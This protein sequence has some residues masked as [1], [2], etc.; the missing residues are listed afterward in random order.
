MAK[1]YMTSW[2]IALGVL[3][4]SAGAAAQDAEAG[5]GLSSE[6][7]E[8]SASGPDAD[9]DESEGVWTPQH[10]F[11]IGIFAGVMFPPEDP[12]LRDSNW[13]KPPA[14]FD[15][16]AFDFGARAGLFPIDYLGLEGELA[17]IPTKTDL[18]NNANVY[19]VRGHLVG[20]IPFRSIT[21][22]LVIGGTTLLQDS[23]E[24]G[25]DDDRAFH[26]GIGA[27]MPISDSMKIRL[28]LRDTISDKQV[29][30]DPPHWP[31]ILLGLSLGLGGE[32]EPPPPPEP[33]DSDGDGL[34]DDVDKCP[35]EPANTPDGCPIPDS[36]GDGVLDPDDECPQEPGTLPNGCPDLDPDKDGILLPADQCPDVAGIAPDGCPDPDPDKDGFLGD[37]DKCPEQP[38]TKNGFEDTDGCPDDVPDKVKKFSGVI[39]GINFAT[40]K[41][42]IKPESFPILDEAVEVLKEY[43]SLNLLISGHTDSVGRPDKNQKL[44][45]DRAASVKAYMVGKGIDASRIE[46]RGAGS[47]EPIADNDTKEGR[48]QNRRI[49]FKILQ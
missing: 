24:L 49:E 43:E 34:T 25:K 36:D 29:R 44:S 42:K 45:D 5:I 16:V 2:C 13:E 40:G 41:S 32:E 23:D 26:F 12:P 11:E 46:T 47:N 17:M 28:D 30:D 8:A 19:A 3:T 9:D 22:F 1:K 7:V 6:G 20:Q 4:A 39:K 15:P 48:A 38:E 33:V 31:E 35:M 14:D 18:G 10:L 27:K 37:A 21:P